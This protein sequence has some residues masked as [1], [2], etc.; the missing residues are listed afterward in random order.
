MVFC[1]ESHYN[2]EQSSFATWAIALIYSN[3]GIHIGLFGAFLFL[4]RVIQWPPLLLAQFCR[5]MDMTVQV[6]FFAV[7][8]GCSGSGGFGCSSGPRLRL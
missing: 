1:S 4:P 2:L 7:P 3:A 6:T 8:E 5:I